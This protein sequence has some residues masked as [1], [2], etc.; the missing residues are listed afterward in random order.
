MTAASGDD[1]MWSGKD[2][3]HDARGVA[4]EK[5]STSKLLKVSSS[6]LLTCNTNWK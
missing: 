2:S 6:A 3:K 4:S 5:R 1:E